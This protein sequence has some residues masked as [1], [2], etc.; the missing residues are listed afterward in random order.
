VRDRIL[1][2]DYHDLDFV[3]E[4]ET[5][6]LARRAADALGGGFY[7]LDNERD[8]SRVVLN[9]PGESRLLLD[10][11]S[12][13]G[14]DL[15]T[16]LRARDYSINAMAMQLGSDDSLIDPCGGLEDLRQKRVRA[17]GPTSLSDDPVRVLRGIRLAVGLGF[18]IE[19]ETLTQLRSAVSLLPRISAER[20][21][22]ELVRILDAKHT[23]LALR[24]LDRVGALQ[25]LLPE[26]TPLKGLL[27]PEPHRLDGWEHTLEVVDHLESLIDVLAGDDKEDTASGLTLASAVLWLGRYREQFKQHLSEALP[28]DR[29]LIGLIKFAALYHDTGKAHTGVVGA[30]GRLHFLGH[31]DVS[32]QLLARRAQALAFSNLEIERAKRIVQGHMRV[33]YLADSAGEIAP[34]SLYRFFRALGDAGIDVCLLSLAD[35]WGTYS[36]TLPQERWLAELQI[37]RKLLEARW[38]RTEAVVRPVRLVSGHDLI[39][40]L[41]LTPGKIVGDLLEVIREAQAAGEVTN[42]DEALTAAANWLKM[43]TGGDL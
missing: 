20:Q 38:E 12:L 35:V 16:D 28:N 17:C 7:I 31:E 34:R 9:R 25:Y 3:M 18:R 10:F 37:C 26:C 15:D 2:R 43:N 5:Q 32:E 11:A 22:D 40:E 24:I 6:G 41:N 14:S 21:R 13:R 27:Q 19:P 8:T 36:T 30:D 4:G 23:H 42:R 1:G 39:K 33:H 29:S